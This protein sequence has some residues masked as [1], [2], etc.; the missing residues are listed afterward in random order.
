M[1]AKVLK[2]FKNKYSK[3]RAIKGDIIEVSKERFKEIN[4]TE[5]GKLV[6]EVKEPKEDKEPKGDKEPKPKGKK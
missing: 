3:K 5:N 6:E 1:K 2:T 4:S